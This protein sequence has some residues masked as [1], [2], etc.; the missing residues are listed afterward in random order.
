MHSYP[1]MCM[2]VKRGSYLDHIKWYFHGIWIKPLWNEEYLLLYLGVNVLNTHVM[3]LIK[4]HMITVFMAWRCLENDN[5]GK[6][7]TNNARIET[8]T[9]PFLLSDRFNAQLPWNVHESKKG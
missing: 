6:H 4:W 2:K 5:L 7:S 1:E 8:W 9:M 3:D